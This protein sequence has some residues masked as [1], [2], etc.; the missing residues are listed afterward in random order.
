MAAKRTINDLKCT[1][2]QGIR[3]LKIGLLIVL[4]RISVVQRETTLT[5]SESIETNSPVESEIVRVVPLSTTE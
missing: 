1:S 3:T 4:S 5:I 2:V